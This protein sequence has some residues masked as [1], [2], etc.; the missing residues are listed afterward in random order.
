MNII[1]K[2]RGHNWVNYMTY[3]PVRAG[4]LMATVCKRCGERGNFPDNLPQQKFVVYDAVTG[5][6]IE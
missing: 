1:C 6:V 2:M 3:V 4:P 5:K